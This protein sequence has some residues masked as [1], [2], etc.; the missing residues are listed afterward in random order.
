M[1]HCTTFESEA[2]TSTE[3]AFER[4]RRT[5][6]WVA[7]EI[8]PLEPSARALLRRMQLP[9]EDIDDVIQECYCQFADQDLGQVMQ[10]RAYFF[11]SLRF[12]VSRRRYRARVVPIDTY[13]EM[14]MFEIEDS[15]PTPEAIAG[16]NMAASRIR[17]MIAALPERCRTIVELR[18]L[19]EW[20]QKRI[21]EHLGITEKVVEKQLWQGVRALRRAWKEQEE[22]GD[23]LGTSA[24]QGSIER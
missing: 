14:R 20:S 10:P 23:P 17:A 19:E 5:V 4:R 6:E 18:K 24:R 13:G 12:I 21:A 8:L 9:P 16:G 11:Q 15:A 3:T 1:A 7:R 22:A 2:H